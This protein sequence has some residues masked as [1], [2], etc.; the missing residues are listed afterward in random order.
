M[1]TKFERR[2]RHVSQLKPTQRLKKGSTSSNFTTAS[3][4]NMK[5]IVENGRKFYIELKTEKD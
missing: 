5:E 3:G 4:K 2:I 1:R